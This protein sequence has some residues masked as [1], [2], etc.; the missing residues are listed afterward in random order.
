M[1]R[2]SMTF[3]PDSELKSIDLNE[4]WSTNKTTIS[5]LIIACV[6]STSFT[7]LLQLSKQFGIASILGSTKKNRTKANTPNF[8]SNT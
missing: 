4:A 8:L 7:L 6:K 1:P 3:L 5:E 2:V